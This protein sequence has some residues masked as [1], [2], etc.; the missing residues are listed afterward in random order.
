MQTAL[1]ALQPLL[2]ATG[3]S[4][5]LKPNAR[6]KKNLG[7]RDTIGMAVGAECGKRSLSQLAIVSADKAALETLRQVTIEATEVEQ[8]WWVTG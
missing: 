7:G 4:L 5:E 2:E 3:L 6:E 1:V 8:Q